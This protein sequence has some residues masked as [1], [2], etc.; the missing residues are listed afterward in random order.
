MIYSEYCYKKL[1]WIICFPNTDGFIAELFLKWC[2]ICA[3]N[4]NS[5][6]IQNK[7]CADRIWL[8]ISCNAAPIMSTCIQCLQ[9]FRSWI[10]VPCLAYNRHREEESVSLLDRYLS[11]WS[12]DASLVR[13]SYSKLNSIHWDFG[14]ADFMNEIQQGYRYTLSVGPFSKLVTFVCCYSFCCNAFD[15][16]EWV[17]CGT[18]RIRC[19]NK[20][21]IL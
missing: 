8:R 2:N 14:N 1:D 16:W 5:R 20:R 18:T 10:F 7:E 12:A 9:F 15:I 21:V 3:H 4:G 17:F 13:P 6:Y 11:L 19:I